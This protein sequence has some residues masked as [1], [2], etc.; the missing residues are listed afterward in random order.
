MKPAVPYWCL[1]AL[2]E[3]ARK[4]GRLFDAG[5]DTL[6][7]LEPTSDH[8][9]A[10]FFLVVAAVWFGTS[11]AAR[12]I[13]S[14]RAIFRRE[15]MVNLGV[16]NYV[17]SKFFVL[18]L[19]CVVQCATLLAIVFPS[20]G[21]AGGASAF[22]SSLGI[23]SLTAL[24][25]V[26]LGLVLSTVVKSSEA[27]MALTPIALIP[28]VVLGGLMVP[29]TTN[30][31]L[32]IPMLAM[33]SRWGFEGIVKTERYAIAKQSGWRIPV[34]NAADSLPDFI[35]GGS[36]ECALAQM[37]SSQLTGAWALGSPPWL[38]VVALTLMTAG[39][40]GLVVLLLKRRD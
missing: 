26:A 18:A 12:E 9:G 10:L 6:S 27:A 23:L 34:E 35:R 36:F 7:R 1:G 8:A 39:S 25:S 11:N 4:N 14:E 32:K 29:V 33:P 2:N 19:L 37:E 17:L 13:V 31:L 38:P 20:L 24:S 21:L 30:A 5:S 3:L 16:T 40:L 28:Q 15:R 22:L